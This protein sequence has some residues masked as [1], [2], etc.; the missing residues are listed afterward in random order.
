MNLSDRIVVF[1][2][3]VIEQMGAPLDIYR[4]PASCCVANFLGDC[5]LLRGEVVDGA[6]GAVRIEGIGVAALPQAQ[7]M[8]AGRAVAVMLRPEAARVATGGPGLQRFRI[9]VDHV[10]HFGGTAVLTGRLGDRALR[11]RLLGSDI[12]A[13]PVFEEAP[14]DF[15]ILP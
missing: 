4:R 11:V 2:Q 15:W 14:V 10:S 13:D 12:P 1:R 6:T 5:N 8:P 9:A 3:G 7:G